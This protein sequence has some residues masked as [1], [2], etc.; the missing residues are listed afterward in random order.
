MK[1]FFLSTLTILCCSVFT[2]ARSQTGWKTFHH[3]NGF[4]IQLPSSF[5]LGL[6]AAGETLQW[7]DNS[8]DKQIELTVETFGNGRVGA[9]KKEFESEQSTFTTVSYKVLK[10]SWYVISG[11]DEQGISYLKTILKNGVLHHLRITYPPSQKAMMNGWIPKIAASF[12]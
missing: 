10:P 6:L 11:E 2:T 1:Q 5:S 4:T 3:K 9:L 7:F 8:F 12:K